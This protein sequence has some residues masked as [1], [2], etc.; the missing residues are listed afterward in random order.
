MG[1]INHCANER[2]AALESHHRLLEVGKLGEDL[3]HFSVIMRYKLQL[4]AFIGGNNMFN[5]YAVF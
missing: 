3:D 5:L 1:Q 4:L 2:L